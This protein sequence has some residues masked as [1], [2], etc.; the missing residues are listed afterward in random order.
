M[1][2]NSKDYFKKIL[3]AKSSALDDEDDDFETVQAE[4]PEL[5]DNCDPDVNVSSEMNEIRNK[6]QA[7]LSENK[8]LIGMLDN[9]LPLNDD[10]EFII[11]KLS[12]PS[13][14]ESEESNNTDVSEFMSVLKDKHNA[15]SPKKQDSSGLDEYTTTQYIMQHLHFIMYKNI[16]Y[17]FTYPG[18]EALDSDEYIARMKEVAPIEVQHEKPIFW[19]NIL[20][21]IRTTRAIYYNLNSVVHP[22]D[23]FILGNGCYNIYTKKFRKALPEDYITAHNAVSFNP[24]NADNGKITEE[25]IEYVSGGN[26]QIKKLIWTMIGVILSPTSQFKKFFYLY[27]R[28]DTGKS[29]IGELCM[30]LVGTANCSYIPLHDLSRQFSLAQL[31]DKQLNCCLDN[32]SEILKNLGNLKVLTSGGSDIIE[33]EK[34]YGK[35]RIVQTNQ[36]K[37]LFA[38]NHPLRVDSHE[39][40]ESFKNRVIVIPCEHVIP[41]DEKNYNLMNELKE[42]KDYIIKKAAKYYRKF[43]DNN[44]VFPYCERSEEL[45]N[46]WFPPKGQETSKLFFGSDYISPERQSIV[47]CKKLYHTYEIYC[48]EN[49]YAPMTYN[50]F[51]KSAR[52]LPYVSNARTE[53]DGQRLQALCGIKIIHD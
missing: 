18:Y 23:E 50:T 44:F 32:R 6:H 14:E 27:G 46:E 33:V 20:K 13:I 30:F 9:A 25:F 10:D 4:K 48:N 22:H 42:E 29:V 7:S 28:K 34:K 2:F 31:S 39:D 16:L 11:K 45:L 51:I 21:N 38:S 43:L 37:L 12:K 49:G 24:D 3:Q 8:N 52:N 26:K 53:E 36:I 15:Q 19:S 5:Y 47:S 41:E 40:V 1:N 35:H 17:L